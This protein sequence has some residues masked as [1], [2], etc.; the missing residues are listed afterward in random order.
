M[1]SEQFWEYFET[2]RERLGGRAK[3]FQAMFE[4]LDRFDRPVRIIE[5]GCLEGGTPDHWLG[6]GCSTILFDRYVDAHPESK[7]VTMDIVEEKLILTKAA[8]RHACVLL[9]DSVVILKDIA[10]GEHRVRTPIDL[11]YLDA[12][13]LDWK[14]PAPAAAHHLNELMAAMPLIR[15][16]TLVVVDNSPPLADGF[17]YPYIGGKGTYVADYALGI[18]AEMV[19]SQYQVGFIG[20]D[21]ATPQG[22]EDLKMLVSRSRHA[23]ETDN[24]MMAGRLYRQIYAMTNPIR[25]GMDRIARAEACAFFAEIA[26]KNGRIGTA[27]D[28]L[29]QAADTDPLGVDYRLDLVQKCFLPIGHMR[30]AV[31]EAERAAAIAPD[32]PRVWKVLGG[33]KHEAND[34]P[35]AL[36]AY[37]QGLAL[38]PDDADALLDRTVIA[39]DL[40]DYEKVVDC[41]N[42]VLGQGGPRSPDALH[43]LGMV[44]YR[45]HRHEDA[46]DYYRAA[47]EAGCQ[48][49]DMAHWNMS[50]A[51]HSIGRYREGWL[52]HE[53]REG[54]KANP[55][56]YI[57]MRRFK[58]PRWTGQQAMINDDAGITTQ[59]GS[60]LVA[61]RRALIH[62]H[63]EAG[64]GDNLATVRYLRMLQN[65]GFRVR[66]ETAPEM[67]DLMRASFPDVEIVPK[68]K[69]Y[70]GAVGIDLFDYHC[71]IGSLPAVF[72]TDIDSIPWFGPY[73]KPDPILV[74]KYRAMLKGRHAIGLCWSSGIRDN[75]IWIKEYGL[76][77]SMHF[78]VAKPIAWAAWR[79]D[80]EVVSLQVGPERAQMSELLDLLPAKP[81]W[82][83]TAALIANLDI[84][85]T[86]DTG[87]AH[88]AG[89][90]GKPVFLMCQ[91]DG[92]SWHFM[93][94]RE[95]ASWNDRSP[96]YPSMRIFRPPTYQPH[97]W[98]QVVKD[99]VTALG[100]P[101]AAE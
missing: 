24:I 46:I 4:H 14:N 50:L 47:I 70:P 75:G 62:V 10:H 72:K 57:P 65:Q 97:D 69:D 73:L 87:V 95:D 67:I 98:S 40:G 68:A 80:L 39:L 33:V 16:E 88:L 66:Y 92:A 99:V 26:I 43:A 11:L 54:V 38:D 100:V 79:S 63:Y 8:C 9:G 78:T 44:A 21:A 3:T 6:N 22:D 36:A 55:A 53:H 42:K 35:G 45:E 25:T 20:M 12:S 34:G 56:L 7:L 93:C 94:W 82:H 60:A 74:E 58:L 37:E 30:A 59:S 77:K 61:P 41:C 96:W 83:E 76:R 91:K 17:P 51:L 86:V 29:R 31:Q 64:A 15:G 27:A 84:V 48:D 85:V 90:M 5:T 1:R 49:V 89:A 19:F 13:H 71:P 32:Y 81:T 2:V 101:Q 23:V 18:G 28:W 52:E